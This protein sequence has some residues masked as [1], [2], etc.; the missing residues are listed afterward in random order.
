MDDEHQII[1]QVLAGDTNAFRQLVESYQ[2]LVFQ[3][4]RNMMRNVE[5]A[6]DLTQDVFVTAFE[7]L[8]TFDAT[9]AKLATWLLTIARNRCWNQ[10]KRR[11]TQTAIDV[12]SLDHGPLPEEAAARNETWRRLNDAL[13]RLPIEQRTA[14]VLAE[15]QELPHAEVAMIE[16]IALGTVKSRVSRARERLRQTLHEW[17]VA[18]AIDGTAGPAKRLQLGVDSAGT[19]TSPAPHPSHGDTHEPG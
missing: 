19:A 8:H 6:E 11:R 9:R 5:D 7:K 15:I 1:E 4:A 13:D 16:K 17:Q 3:F 18:E 10:L 2:T 12:D 14:F